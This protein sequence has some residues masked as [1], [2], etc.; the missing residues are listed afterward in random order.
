VIQERR[1]HGVR[2]GPPGANYLVGYDVRKTRN[3]K[4]WT[5]IATAWPH[6]K[7]KE[8]FTVELNAFPVTETIVFLPP[9]PKAEAKPKKSEE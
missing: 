9:E 1:G 4:I 7:D 8:G 3:G 2:N 5:R 6:H